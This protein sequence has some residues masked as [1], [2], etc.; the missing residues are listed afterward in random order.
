MECYFL[1]LLF[2]DY[3]FESDFLIYRPYFG[4]FNLW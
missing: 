4:F 2:F 1:G 3:Y